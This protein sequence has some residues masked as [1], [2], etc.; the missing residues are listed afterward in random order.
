LRDPNVDSR[1]NFSGLPTEFPQAPGT[2]RQEWR[3]SHTKF[4]DIFL[5][6]CVFIPPTGLMDL[7]EGLNVITFGS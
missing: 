7:I 2:F 3:C 4:A 5:M 6:G 1:R